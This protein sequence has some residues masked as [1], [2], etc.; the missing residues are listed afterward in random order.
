M[1]HCNCRKDNYMSRANVNNPPRSTYTVPRKMH[2][3][4]ISGSLK[5]NLPDDWAP[6]VRYA[7]WFY[8]H[9]LAV[10]SEGRNLY[11]VSGVIQFD[12]TY[13]TFQVQRILGTCLSYFNSFPISLWELLRTPREFTSC[14]IGPKSYGAPLLI[15]PIKHSDLRKKELD[16]TQ[17][18]RKRMETPFDTDI[19]EENEK[20]TEASQE[21]S[22][23]GC[24]YG[25]PLL[26]ILEDYKFNFPILSFREDYDESIH[27][28]TIP[29]I[30]RNDPPDSI[31]LLY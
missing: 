24:I 23:R 13:T 3:F 4:N 22:L 5:S 1:R 17:K 15:P 25:A 10:S 26:T 21:R 29:V 11:S 20:E 16:I 6:Y 28:S 31:I 18:K 7:C 12:R 27:N 30:N 2:Y 19:E 8:R 9:E 14:W